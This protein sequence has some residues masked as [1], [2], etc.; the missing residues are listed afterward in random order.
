MDCDIC[1]LPFKISGPQ[2]PKVLECGH[3]FC[4]MCVGCLN[5]Q[6]ATCRRSFRVT[7]TNFLLV[8][9]L[10]G[11]ADSISSRNEQ[12]PERSISQI[13]REIEER[14]RELELRRCHEVQNQLLSIN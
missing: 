2:E 12:L 7:S 9:L 8:Q 13:E 1:F 3:T 5:N 14:K 10:D 6:C 4:S 11:K